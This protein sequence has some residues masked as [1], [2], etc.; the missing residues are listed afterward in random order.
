VAFEVARDLAE[1]IDIFLRQDP[2]FGVSGPEDGSRVPL[3]QDE[4]VVARIAG[5]PDVVSHLVE[6]QAGHE[7]GGGEAG[8]RVP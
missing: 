7:F 4:L 1:R 3:G 6:E 8:R 5:V 2:G